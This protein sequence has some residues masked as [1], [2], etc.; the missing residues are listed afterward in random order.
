[1]SLDLTKASK[2]EISMIEMLITNFY[3]S[4]YQGD[5]EFTVDGVRHRCHSR[6]VEKELENMSSKVEIYCME[7]I[8]D[9]QNKSLGGQCKKIW[10]KD[11]CPKCRELQFKNE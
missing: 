2:E 7:H 8:E 4:K 9:F 3:H 6:T 1:V 11:S 5:M 10:L